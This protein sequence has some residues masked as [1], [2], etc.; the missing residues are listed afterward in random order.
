MIT[1]MKNNQFQQRRKLLLGS[2]AL[3]LMPKIAFAAGERVSSDLNHITA[4]RVLGKSDAPIKVIELFS[5][6]CSHCANFHNNS[7]GEITERLI[8]TG[9]VQF[10][11]RPF[12]LDQV[13]LRGHALARALPL[14]KYFPMVSMLLKDISR[15]AQAEDPIRALS[16]MARLAGMGGEEF[17]AVMRN[18][19]LLEAIVGI[20]QA[21]YS[22]WNI[23][24]T[25]S[26]IVN[27]KTT[28]SGAMSYE[29]FADKINAIGA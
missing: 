16:Q 27:G 21:S 14:S 2:A 15:W 13:A 28:L 6:T 8:D 10:E 26:F 25:P 29:E 11:M 19:E 1:K 3:A 22:Q 12:P 5:M 17:D 9:M 24:S 4:P 18:R 20:R 7:F 23:Q